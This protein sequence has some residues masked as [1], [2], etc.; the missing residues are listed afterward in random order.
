MDT[1]RKDLVRKRRI[2]RIVYSVVAAAAM[3]VITFGFSRLDPATPTV[4]DIEARTGIDTY[5]NDVLPLLR[6]IHLRRVIAVEQE[7]FPRVVIGE[8]I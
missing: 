3:G 4:A 5:V 1:P 6:E 7:S 8:P 2:C